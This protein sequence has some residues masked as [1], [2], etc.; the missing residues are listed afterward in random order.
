MTDD[1]GYVCMYI[2][3]SVEWTTDINELAYSDRLSVGYL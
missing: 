3:T 1:I 2:L